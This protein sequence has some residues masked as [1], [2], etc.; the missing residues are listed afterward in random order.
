MHARHTLIASAVAM[1]CALPAW[2]QH[3]T[4]AGADVAALRKDLEA[5]RRHY[6]ARIQAI[7]ERIKQAEARVGQAVATAETARQ[8]AQAATQAATPPVAAN[9]FNPEISLI[10][11]GRYAH[12]DDIPK[13]LITGYLPLSDMPEG[14]SRGFSVDASELS[15]A[16]NIDPWFRGYANIVYTDEAVEV[17]EAYFQ[18]LGL[19]GGFTV[20]GGRFRS[21]LGYMN[22][23]HP[24]QWD[25][26][27]NPLM[28]QALFGEGYIQD[29]LQ[30]KWIAP[31]DLLIELTGDVGRGAAFPGSDRDDNGAN[32]YTL[33]VHLGGDAGPSNSWRAGVSYLHTEA[34]DRPFFGVDP[35][36]VDV[37]GTFTGRSKTW[38]ADVVW[39]WAPGGNPRQTHFKFQAEWFKR[40]EAGDLSCSDPAAASLTCDGTPGDYDADQTGWYV[41]GV[42]QFMPRWRVGYRYDRLDRGTVN[43]L[44][45]DAGVTLASLADHNA[46]KHSLMLDWSPSEFSRLRLQYARDQSMQGIEEDQYSL[47]YIY[48]LGTHGAHKF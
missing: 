31:A 30:A 40:E 18:T 39:K 45:A 28:Y 9:S 12:L 25:F 14:P 5:L 37:T 3:T 4:D 21:A 16:A 8:D 32:A 44:G 2:A 17:E 26:V 34:Q 35:A 43:F 19:G 6:E 15:I 7:E 48:S 47:Q 41:Q 22:E 29:G 1:V 46:D 24:H 11:A 36:A 42:Y 38:L 27:D 23:Q 10:L 33:G 20:K 13:R